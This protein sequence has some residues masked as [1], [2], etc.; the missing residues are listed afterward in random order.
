MMWL[1][2]SLVLVVAIGLVLRRAVKG[3]ART[4]HTLGRSLRGLLRQ[5][6]DGG[7]LIIDVTSSERFLQF[8]KY[9]NAPGDYGI[10]LGFPRGPWSEQ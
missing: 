10:Y 8:A 1:V 2:I 6:Y 7:Y 9:I 5:G 3:P 4:V